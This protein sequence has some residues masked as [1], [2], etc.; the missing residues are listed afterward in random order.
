VSPCKSV[1]KVSGHRLVLALYKSDFTC[2]LFCNGRRH[3]VAVVNLRTGEEALWT[4]SRRRA[5]VF[6]KSSSRDRRCGTGLIRPRSER[7][8]LMITL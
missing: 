8:H 1:I 3:I 4:A 6:L 2:M 5:K 7:T